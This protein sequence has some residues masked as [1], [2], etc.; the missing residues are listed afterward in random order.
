MH[1]ALEC[2]P[3][4]CTEVHWARGACRRHALGTGVHAEGVHWGAL[5]TGVHAEGVHLHSSAFKVL[6]NRVP[7]GALSVLWIEALAK[8]EHGAIRSAQ[9][10]V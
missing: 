5:G 8:R 6:S 2:T 7:G 1:W 9:V 10:G 3:K 4:A